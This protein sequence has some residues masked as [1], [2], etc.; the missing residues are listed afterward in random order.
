LEV[1]DAL[2]DELWNMTLSVV[3]HAEGKQTIKLE[4]F[5]N[6]PI[7]LDF[8]ATSCPACIT[9]LQKLDTIQREL[10][11]EVVIIPVTN[12]SMQKAESFIKTQKW[13]LPTVVNNSILQEYFPHK[14]IPHYIWVNQQGIIEAITG[15]DPVNKANIKTVID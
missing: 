14:Y 1:G 7:I 5:R 13:Q 3:N 8:W 10:A 2:P 4:D 9:S 6:T 11:N 15:A 12:D